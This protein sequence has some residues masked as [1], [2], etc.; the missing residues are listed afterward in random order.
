M[1]K[2]IDITDKW[3]SKSMDMNGGFNGKIVGKSGENIGL[4]M[5]KSTIPKLWQMFN[6]LTAIEPWNDGECAVSRVIFQLIIINISGHCS[7]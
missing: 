2:T 4:F 1:D 3:V 7:E 5:V 6:N